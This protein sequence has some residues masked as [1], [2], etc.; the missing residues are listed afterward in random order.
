MRKIVIRLEINN[1]FKKTNGYWTPKIQNGRSVESA[2]YLLPLQFKIENRSGS[3]W[4]YSLEK[5][6]YETL[7]Q[8]PNLFD[9]QDGSKQSVSQFIILDPVV[10]LSHSPIR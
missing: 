1:A 2:T 9:F 8:F 6:Y 3:G 5:N 10:F 7:D 4:V